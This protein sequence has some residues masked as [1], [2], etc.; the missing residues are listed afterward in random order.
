M[1]S[2]HLCFINMVFL[3]SMIFYFTSPVFA[4]PVQPYKA[5]QQEFIQNSSDTRSINSHSNNMVNV[6]IDTKAQCH[7]DIPPLPVN[8]TPKLITKDLGFLEGPT[9]SSVKQQFYFSEMDFDGPQTSGPISTIYTWSHQDGVKKL[10]NDVGTNGLYAKGNELYLLDHANRGISKMNLS[11]LNQHVITNQFQGQHFNSPNDAV[12]DKDEIL[13]FTDPDWQLGPREQQ[14]PYTGVY[15]LNKQGHAQLINKSLNKPNGI[16]LS[17]DEKHI[18]IGDYS[19][20]IYVYRLTTD[21]TLA[22]ITQ[23]ISIDTPDGMAIDCAGNLYATSHNEG[24]IKIYN[25]KGNLIQS[26]FIAPKL[27]NVAF[28]GKDMKTLLITT[29]NGLFKLTTKVPG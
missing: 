23:K 25:K 21:K 14:T 24:F 2:K 29:G 18:Y 3:F 16:A 8:P 9:W 5:T 26:V 1:G 10:I 11:S 13:Y 4:N 27:T 20:H 12:M 19:H 28:G 17:K 6:A 15:T 22:E 7:S